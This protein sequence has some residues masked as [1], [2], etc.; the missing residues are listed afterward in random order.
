MGELRQKEFFVEEKGEVSPKRTPEKKKGGIIRNIPAGVVIY[1]EPS[2]RGQL[3]RR[4]KEGE[5]FP[6]RRAIPDKETMTLWFAGTGGTEYLEH[7]P[8]VLGKRPLVFIGDLRQEI[9]RK[10]KQPSKLQYELP[11]PTKDS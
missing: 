3:I 2:Y 8:T 11:L 6:W 1:G 9:P 5:V 10:P 7:L 4:T